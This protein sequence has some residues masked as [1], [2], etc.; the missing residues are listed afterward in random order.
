[1]LTI[2]C[3]EEKETTVLLEMPETTLWMAE[4]AMTIWPEE[5]ETILTFSKRDTAQIRFR[6]PR[7]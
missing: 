4:K 3:P 1:M 6:M 5:P 7:E 2:L